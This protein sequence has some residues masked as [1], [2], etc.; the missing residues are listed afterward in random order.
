LPAKPSPKRKVKAANSGED[1]NART[2]H[3]VTGFMLNGLPALQQA[4]LGVL[5]NLISSSNNVSKIIVKSTV[6]RGSIYMG[7]LQ[8]TAKILLWSEKLSN[9]PA[10]VL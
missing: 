10:G 2:V 6:D 1:F 5:K 4:A 3:Q 8:E 9:K 7:M